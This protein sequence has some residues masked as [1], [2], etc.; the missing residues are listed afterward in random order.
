VQFDTFDVQ[1]FG[2]DPSPA[3]DDETE[4]E[5]WATLTDEWH[6]DFRDRVLIWATGT[7]GGTGGNAV[8][9]DMRTSTPGGKERNRLFTEQAEITAAEIDGSDATPMLT[10]DGDSILRMHVHNARRRP[11]QWGVSLSKETRDSS[12]LVDMAVAMVGARLGRR[13]VL[14]SGKARKKRTGRASFL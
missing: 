5:Y 7:P 10:H 1:W 8:L 13:L 11:N 6:R 14:N 3:R 9:F 12:K 4:H 2:V